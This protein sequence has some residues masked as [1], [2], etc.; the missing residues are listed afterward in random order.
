M[1]ILVGSKTNMEC[2]GSECQKSSQAEFDQTEAVEKAYKIGW[3]K[4]SNTGK[5]FCPTCKFSPN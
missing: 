3:I 2:D 4:D 1:G 5:T